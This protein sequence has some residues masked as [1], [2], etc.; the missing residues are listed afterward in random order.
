MTYAVFFNISVLCYT[1]YELEAATTLNVLDM[2]ASLTWNGLS[3][4][5]LKTG[6]TYPQ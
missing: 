3:L 1:N 5:V 2:L 4:Q 6:L